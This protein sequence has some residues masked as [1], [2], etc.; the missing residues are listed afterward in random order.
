MEPD[1]ENLEALALGLIL[2]KLEE[3]IDHVWFGAVCKNWRSIAKF[4]HQ[5]Q[6]FRTHVLPML[7]IPRTNICLYS[8]PAKRMYAF[9][10]P[11]INYKIT[12][13]GNSH[14][15][16]ALEDRNHVV[17]ILNP[18]KNV[19]HISLPPLNNAYKSSCYVVKKV[20]LSA[21]PI[22]RPNDYVVL[23][24]HKSSSLAF[25]KAGQT[26]WTYY[27]RNCLFFMDVMFYKD[28]VYGVS[29]CRG[30]VSFNLDLDDPYGVTIIPTNNVVF[31]GTFKGYLVKSLEGDLWLVKRDLSFEY[32]NYYT[33]CFQVCKLEFD[34]QS[35]KVKQMV[36][37]E[38]LGDNV[39]FVGEN[40]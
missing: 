19:A 34:A 17:T 4:N 36:K 26:C 1:W 13:C 14:G 39:L 10:F 29:H 28:L 8:I 25:I 6:Q 30:I 15:W 3:R 7:M 37:L 27:I 31:H 2:D 38:S 9:K 24:I 23:A 12:C 35:G 33:I 20:T 18:F 32:N 22:I 21:D 11:I 16:L 40:T 5:N